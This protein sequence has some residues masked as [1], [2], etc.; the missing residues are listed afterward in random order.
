MSTT[1]RARPSAT[2]ARTC[3][4]ASS[5]SSVAIP[6]R[7]LLLATTNP[8]KADE[9]RAILEPLGFDVRTLGTLAV[10]PDEPEE[11]ELTFAGNARLKARYYAERTGTPCVAEDSGLEVDALGGAPGV[12][13]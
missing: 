6:V 7:P 13:S 3:A 5:S 8:H 10:V 4:S 11:T 1:S 2:S 12:Y 9:V